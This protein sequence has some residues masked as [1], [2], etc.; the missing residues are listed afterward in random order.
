MNL[1]AQILLHFICVMRIYILQKFHSVNIHLNEIVV[2][3][4]YKNCFVSFTVEKPEQTYFWLYL[5][6]Y[7]HKAQASY[8]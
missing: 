4:V 5:F 1:Q 7:T 6:M 8:K 2:W 3:E